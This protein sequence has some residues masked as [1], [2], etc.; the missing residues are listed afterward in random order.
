MLKFITYI[1]LFIKNIFKK[2]M[3]IFKKY[4]N[5]LD[6]VMRINKS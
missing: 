3:K 5:I 4:I 6:A 2:S 1:I